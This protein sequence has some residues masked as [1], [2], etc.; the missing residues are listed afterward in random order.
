MNDNM[1]KP[2]NFALYCPL[3]KHWSKKEADDPC[4]ECLDTFTNGG[5]RVPAKFE[6]K[7]KRTK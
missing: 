2:V 4:F 6:E 1:L 5:S 3:C 7:E